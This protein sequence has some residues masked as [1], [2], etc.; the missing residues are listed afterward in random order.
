MASSKVE[1]DLDPAI[2]SYYAR[3]KEAQ[4]LSQGVGE[5]EWVR[6][7]EIIG[8]YLPPAPAV[9]LD[10]GGGPGRYACWLA[11]QGYETHLVDPVRL[12]VGQA[13]AASAAQPASPLAGACQG[14]ARALPH[15][16]ASADLVLLFG[17]LYHL[18][19]ETDRATALREAHRVLR[20]G[21]RVLAVGI[22]RFASALDGLLRGFIDDPEFAAIVEQDLADGQHRNPTARPGYFTTAFLHR[23]EDLQ[24]E[25]EEGGFSWETTLAVQ[26]P[27]W[28]MASFE[29]RWS[30][31]PRRERLLEVLRRL[32]A[33]P[34]L[35]GSTGHLLAVG[36]KPLDATRN[37]GT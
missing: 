33:E 11:R 4:R 12:H 28:L 21:G 25:L 1:P 30:D 36:R 10:V 2:H 29:E 5:L 20:P 31:P 15:A 37:Q 14:D 18:T 27:A 19:E 16:D 17:P 7:T 13:L 22:S 8:R 23:P 9:V 24:G 26:G 6:L 34:S 32:E 35:S 3:G